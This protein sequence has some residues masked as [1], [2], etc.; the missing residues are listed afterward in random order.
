MLAK[1]ERMT[2]VQ[3]KVIK[4]FLPVK[5]KLTHDLRDVFILNGNRFC[6]NIIA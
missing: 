3:W 1:F 6:A 2:D 5:R 4:D